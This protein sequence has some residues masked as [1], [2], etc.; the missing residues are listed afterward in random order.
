M[1]VLVALADEGAEA[2]C[3]APDMTQHHCI[4]HFTGD[5]VLA[6]P[7]ADRNVLHESARIARGKVKDVAALNVSEFDAL[8]FPGGFGVAKNL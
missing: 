3:F 1:A 7:L 4:N 2:Q 6:A 8:V 5:N